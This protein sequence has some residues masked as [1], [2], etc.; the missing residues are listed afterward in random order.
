MRCSSVTV[1]DDRSRVEDLDAYAA[2]REALRRAARRR[3]R[4]AVVGLAAAL[5]AAAGMIAAL[6][7]GSGGAPADAPSGPVST[8]APASQTTPSAPVRVRH[9]IVIAAVG[10]TMLGSY[11]VVPPD[12]AAYLAPIRPALRAPLVYGNLEG[13]LTDRTEDKCGAAAIDCFA[14]R[15]P[16]RYARYLRA[17]GFDVLSNANNHSYD[18]GAGGQA[19]TV[20]ALHAAGIAQTG[21]PGEITVVRRGGVS[22]AFVAFAP[23]SDTASLLDLPAARS[24]VAAAAARADIVV[25]GIH[26]GA[27]GAAALHLT[28]GEERYA[29]EDRGNPEVFAH[30]AVDA[31]ADLVVGSGPH[32]VRAMEVYRGR[33]IAYSLGNFA[34]YHNFGLDGDLARSVILRVRLSAGGAFLGGRLVSVRLVDAGR[35]EVDPSRAGARLVA[36]LTRADLRGGGLAIAADG[37]L[38]AV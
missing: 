34:G 18:F 9:G 21:L 19:D 7:A 36:E 15:A 14:F 33:L 38:R 4:L 16:L 26:A 32:V 29:G 8:R 12:P 13:T 27:E 28:A 22:V 37:R 23:Y 3:R 20:A 11:P 17:A 24:L 30:A 31:G 5:A 10:D 1:G 35:P 6:V 25:V 2:R